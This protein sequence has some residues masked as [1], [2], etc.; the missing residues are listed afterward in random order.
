MVLEG[1]RISLRKFTKED[2]YEY[3]RATDDFAIKRYVPFAHPNNLDESE[4]LI[5]TYSTVDFKNDFYFLIVDNQSQ[6][7]LGS[8]LCFKSSSN[9]LNVSY[10]IFPNFRGKGFCLEALFIFINYISKN[11]NYKLLEFSVRSG[12]KASKKVMKKLRAKKVGQ[13][14]TLFFY[15]YHIKSAK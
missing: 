1:K 15:K 14:D 5:K 7:M 11:T 3:L 12:N 2:T 10:L 13:K 4:E 8:L 9:T 6:K